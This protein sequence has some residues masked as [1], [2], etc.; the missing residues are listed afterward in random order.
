MSN[1]L[2]CADVLDVLPTLGRFKCLIMDPPDNI[3][4]HYSEFE[5]D[6]PDDEYVA[7]LDDVIFR[8]IKHADIVWVSFNA[9][10]IFDVGLI[11]KGVKEFFKDYEAR[12]FI[13][14]FT[15]GQNRNSD[16]GNG[17]RP[18]LRLKH[19][20]AKLYPQAIRVPSWRQLNGDKRAA[21]GGR[22]PLD[23]W[24][25]FPRITGNCKERRSW[26][27]TQLREGMIE[28]IIQ[29][30]TLPG[31][32]IC[33]CF[34]GTGTVLRAAGNLGTWGV[35]ES[36]GVGWVEPRN[37]VTSIEIDPKYCSAIAAEHGLNVEMFNRKDQHETHFAGDCT[38]RDAR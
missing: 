3:G 37:P 24:D 16:C 36:D 28:R 9:K 33:D 31:E 32:P 7:W 6:K 21:V 27:P 5:D 25:E 10:W 26:H 35:Y 18:L 34:S 8:A 17:Y 12:L 13:Q 15:F 14:S 20:D 19:R 22:V 30:S 2:I 4:L 1:R 11:A 29:F 38:I 23:C